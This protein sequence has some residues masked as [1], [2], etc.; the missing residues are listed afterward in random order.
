[1]LIS[2]IFLD[3]EPSVFFLFLNLLGLTD[4]VTAVD[5]DIW[6]EYLELLTAIFDFEFLD[7]IL[8]CGLD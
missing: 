4:F 5:S 6:T 3:S 1:M 2:S 8:V 7:A